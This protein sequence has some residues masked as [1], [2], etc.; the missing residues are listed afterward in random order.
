MTLYA[1]FVLAI[2]AVNLWFDYAK[3]RLVVEDR[4]SVFGALT[5]AVRF[6]RRT[7]PTVMALYLLDA[8]LFGGVLAAYA[9]LASLTPGATSTW[10][11]FVIGQLYVA[12]RLWVKLVFWASATALFQGHESGYTLLSIRPPTEAP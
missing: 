10:M 8:A 5:A 11:A 2:A 6:V 7:A 9:G 3:V 1:A 4:R 12:A